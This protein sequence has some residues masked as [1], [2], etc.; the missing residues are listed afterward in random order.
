MVNVISPMCIR[1]GLFLWCFLNSTAS[2]ASFDFSPQCDSA[3]AEILNLRI[4]KAKT[5]LVLATQADPDNKVPL[6]LENYIDFLA[7]Y[8]NEEESDFDNLKKVSDARI[9]I[10]KKDKS[11]SPY[12]LYIQAE[13]HLHLAFSKFKYNE[14]FTGLLEVRRAFKLIEQNRN[15]YPDFRPNLKLHGLLNALIG[16]IPGKYGW[17]LRLFG[18]DGDLVYGMG[19]LKELSNE[20]YRFQQETR[21]L[22]SF[23][24]LYLESK[25]N[26]GYAILKEGNEPELG[27]KFSYYAM[28]TMALYSKQNKQADSLLNFSLNNLTEEDGYA[29]FPYLNYLAGVVKLQQLNPEAKRHFDA[30]LSVQ[31]GKNNIKSTYQK[32]AWF[33]LLND[34]KEAYDQ[35]IAKVNTEGQSVIDADVQAQKEHDKEQVPAKDLL[36]ARLLF[37]GGYFERALQILN[38]SAYNGNGDVALQLETIYRKA[39]VYDEM[40]DKE[41]AVESYLKTVE[42]GSDEKFYFAANAALHL[43][44]LYEDR[45]ELET[46]AMHFKQALEMKD[47]E[48][49]NSIDQ[50]AK[51]A[52]QRIGK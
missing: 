15:K 52:L 1:I 31:K 6:L 11:N 42:L 27:N 10:V 47:H 29:A 36:K 20:N 48:Y 18:M 25:P 5:H 2:W 28:A 34:D 45:G 40:G 14:Y 21:I 30:F 7:V 3:Y 4:D 44:Y 22:Y 38:A 51:A 16:V 26:K 13:I 50:K 37:D 39:R 41:K 24:L 32:L 46:A 49:K 23:L 17:G 8:L 9:D 19:L 43:G 12:K 33:S 35:Y